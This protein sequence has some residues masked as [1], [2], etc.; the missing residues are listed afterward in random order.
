[1]KMK[2]RK[3]IFISKNNLKPSLW[4]ETLRCVAQPNAID[5]GAFVLE[6]D[7]ANSI[8]GFIFCATSNINLNH[9]KKKYLLSNP[10]YLGQ[11]RELFLI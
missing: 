2:E 7:K 6:P 5:S 4:K 9:S 3:S 8:I 10:Y 1:M 11:K